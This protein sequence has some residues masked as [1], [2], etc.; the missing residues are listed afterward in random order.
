MNLSVLE[1]ED[2]VRNIKEEIQV[3]KNRQNQ[4]S[5]AHDLGLLIEMLLSNITVNVH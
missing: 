2:L 5:D 1:N 4:Y 3:V